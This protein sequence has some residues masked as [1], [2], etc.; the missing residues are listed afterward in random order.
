MKE[1]DYTM[2]IMGT[3]S[4]LT[5]RDDQDHHR[6][7]SENGQKK[8]T[9]FKYHEPF[10]LHFNYRH[11]VDDHNNLRHAVPSVEETWVTIR[12]ALCVLQFLMAVTEVNMYLCM[13]FWDGNENSFGVQKSNGMGTY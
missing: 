6:H 8:S 3:A 13:R 4:G 5:V 9:T 12:W 10:Y 11:I 7:W 1:P 2:K